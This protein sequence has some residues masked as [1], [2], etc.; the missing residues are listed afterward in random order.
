V[1]DEPMKHSV[2]TIVSTEQLEQSNGDA[3]RW[4]TERI[5]RQ[6]VDLPGTMLRCI[7]PWYCFGRRA[8][9][10]VALTKYPDEFAQ[11]LLRKFPDRYQLYRE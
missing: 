10:Q 3:L 4:Q 9:V 11:R 8:G 7:E 1:A 2:M 5:A 6:L